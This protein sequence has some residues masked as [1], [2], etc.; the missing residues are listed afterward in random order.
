[1][2]AAEAIRPTKHALDRFR[3][4]VMPLLPEDKRTEYRKYSQMKH[5]VNRVE[6]YTEDIRKAA[7]GLLKMDVFLQID[8]V[9]PIPLTYVIDPV[10]KLIVTLYTQSGWEVT[11]D[12]GEMKLRWSA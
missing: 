11:S 5:L 9:P 1:M 3:Q 10:E 2:S 7:G 8:E 6:L 12:S 4:R